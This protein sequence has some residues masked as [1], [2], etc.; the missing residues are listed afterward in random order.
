M[1]T[2]LSFEM[3]YANSLKTIKDMGV[4]THNRTGIDTKAIQHQYFYIKCPQR[5]FPML[6]GKKVYPK[7]ALKEL[8][9]MMMGRTD[10]QWLHDH[11]V[12]YW[13]EWVLEDGTIGHSYGHQYRDFNGV[14]QIK[15]LVDG[16][17]NNPTSRRHIVNL[18][19][20]SDLDKMALP[21][22][23]YD[24]HYSCVPIGTEASPLYRVDLHSRAR[25]NDSFLGVPYDFMFCGWFMT[26]IVT[27]LNLQNNGNKYVVGDLHYTA[28]DYHMYVN[29]KDAVEQYLH[30][31]E[32]NRDLVVSHSH[33]VCYINAAIFEGK[34][35]SD[36]DKFLDI[37]EENIS[38]KNI[39]I[40]N[41]YTVESG[42]EYGPIK[43]EIAV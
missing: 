7:M 8:V 40:T 34:D 29:H 16:M 43:A 9:W 36:I 14:D 6:R 42:F 5:N 30:N 37:I 39:A 4:V 19:N 33:S 31:V 41:L 2:D 21:P 17:L 23:M 10:I 32:E 25:S 20:A 27:Y 18:W 35:V 24:Y 38:T 15:E 26:L 22:C 1:N 13:D 28:D 11:K 12:T 3:Q